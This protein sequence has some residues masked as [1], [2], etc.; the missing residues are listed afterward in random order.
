MCELTERV[1][2]PSPKGFHYSDFRTGCNHKSAWRLKTGYRAS[3]CAPKAFPAA[4]ALAC[5]T[6]FRVWL[7]SGE[8]RESLRGSPSRERRLRD[9]ARF[10]RGRKAT[11]G[12]HPV[13]SAEARFS[14]KFGTARAGP[15]RPAERFSK[16]SSTSVAPRGKK[17]GFSSL[18]MHSLT[19]C[20]RRCTGLFSV[21]IRHDA[22]D[23]RNSSGCYAT[24]RGRT[25]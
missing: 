6:D 19:L 11:W 16:F 8:P 22:P 3:T 23:G 13:K 1:C 24:D 20:F 14:G 7:A 2:R 15:V 12:A 18:M 9:F 25:V 17:T 10:C 4:T 5:S 21:D